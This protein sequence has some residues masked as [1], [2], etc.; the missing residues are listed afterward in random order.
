MLWVGG[1]EVASLARLSPHS[2][3]GWSGCQQAGRAAH[4]AQLRTCFQLA[5]KFEL[6]ETY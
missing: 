5:M 2:S 1:I 4:S 6:E 3:P